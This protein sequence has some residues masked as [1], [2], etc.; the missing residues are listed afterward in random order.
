VQIVLVYFKVLA[1]RFVTLAQRLVSLTTEIG[2][3][4]GVHLHVRRCALHRVAAVG[5]GS[6]IRCSLRR[7]RRDPERQ[8]RC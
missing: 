8:P 1:Q 5:R 4:P 7:W 6:R 3:L 2:I